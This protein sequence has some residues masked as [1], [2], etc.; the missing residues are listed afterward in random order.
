MNSPK[1]L[2]ITNKEDITVDFVVNE[3]NGRRID[4]YR[5]NTED[6]GETLDV[7]I[8]LDSNNFLL[9]DE[10]K[11]IDLNSFTS[12]YYRR[13]KAPQI[14]D[15]TVGEQVY[16][17]REHEALLEGIYQ[18][19]RNKKWLNNV[20]SIRLAE[21]KIYQ[22][23]IA[24]EIGLLTPKRIITNERNEA[25][26][27]VN[28]ET[29]I[30]K[31]MKNG[32]IEE[33]NMNSK[34]LFTNVVDENFINNISSI[35]ALPVYFQ[36]LIHKRSD[37]RVTVVDEIIN[38]VEIDS[39]NTKDAEIDWRKSKEIPK[40]KIITLDEALKRQV[41]ELCKRFD[42][43]FAAIDFIRNTN[44]EMVFLEINPNGQ[45]GWIEKLLKIDISSQ[46]VDYMVC[47]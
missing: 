3:L 26:N 37:I 1:V 7:Y 18:F 19:L 15:L 36:N 6:I 17:I 16:Y 21:N 11:V 41:L 20:Y 29:A 34:I 42:L 8:N 33:V 44:N 5:L 27:F 32:F 2:I 23:I 46:I 9:Y 13:P 4:F 24:N 38:A 47:I 10:D 12:V 22:Q 40:H 14:A 30:F 28:N 35:K 45:W 25:L 31:P 43:R 39:Q